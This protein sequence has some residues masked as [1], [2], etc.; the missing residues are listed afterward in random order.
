MRL[1]SNDTIVVSDRKLIQQVLSKE[2]YEGRPWNEFMKLRN[3]GM[4]KG[5]MVLLDLFLNVKTLS[6]FIF[7][8]NAET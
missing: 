3:L 5:I 2:E 4:R 7:I 6:F 1:G 8:V